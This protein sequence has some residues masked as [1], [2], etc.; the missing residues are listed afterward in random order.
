[1]ASDASPATAIVSPC[2]RLCMVDGRSGLCA[3]CRR[4]LPEIARWG[5]MTDAER[6]TV[7]AALP[8]RPQPAPPGA[9][10]A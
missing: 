4:T 8:G 2:V 7:V 3:G 6:Q 9:F 10:P 1:M 5:A